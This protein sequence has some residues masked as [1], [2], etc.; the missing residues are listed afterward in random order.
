MGFQT[1]RPLYTQQNDEELCWP[2]TISPFRH[3]MPI[4][5]HRKHELHWHLAAAESRPGD[6]GFSPTSQIISSRKAGI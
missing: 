3:D 1:L 5:P 2:L 6:Y 4:A